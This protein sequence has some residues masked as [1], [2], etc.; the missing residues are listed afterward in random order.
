M[1]VFNNGQ[2]NY[3]YL[4]ISTALAEPVYSQA[5]AGSQQNALTW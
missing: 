2:P 1:L 3:R 4:E 5:L